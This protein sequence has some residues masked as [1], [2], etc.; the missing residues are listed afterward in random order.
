MKQHY[1]AATA[2]NYIG[3]APRQASQPRNSGAHLNLHKLKTS[4]DLS[5]EALTNPSRLMPSRT[6]LNQRS[7]RIPGSERELREGRT[8][9]Q[10]I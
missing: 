4:R 6:P 8:R 2:L 3:T 5:A 7:F 1:T 9:K 10:R